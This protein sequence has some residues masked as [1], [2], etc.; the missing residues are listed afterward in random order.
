MRNDLR[1][2]GSAAT[3]D[4]RAQDRPL[5]RLGGAMTLAGTLLSFVG[6]ALHPRSV[7]FYGDP[8]AWL[9]HNTGSAVWFPSHVMILLGSILLVGGL[10]ALSGSL[11][12]TRGYGVGQLALANGLIGS[13]LIIVTLAID[14]LAVAKLDDVWNAAAAPSP[15]AL[16]AGSILYHTIFSLLY[17]FMLTLFGLAPIFY[18]IAILLSRAYAGWLGWA[19]ILIGSA[20]VATGLLSMLGVATE[21][22]D[23]LVWPVVASFFTAW[24]FVIGAIM[25]RR[26]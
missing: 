15:D 17:V 25:W 16:L 10:V 3:V 14:G 18:G 23:A 19:A 1:K 5:L 8:A 20:V 7:G 26:A 22:L 2:M 11:A 4:P 21:V 6:N 24:F 12:G 13:A 9:D